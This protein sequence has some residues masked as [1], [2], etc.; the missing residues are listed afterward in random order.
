MDLN[1]SK[2]CI[3]DRGQVTRVLSI[4]E[5]FSES[6]Y[7]GI[8]SGMPKIIQ[9]GSPSC[10]NQTAVSGRYALKTLVSFRVVIISRA[11]PGSLL[12]KDKSEPTS[13][14]SSE[15]GNNPTVSKK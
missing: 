7:I 2:S 3:V 1:I 12:V 11:R 9:V 13:L 4:K 5:M 14:S 8:K 10:Q 6:I 15:R